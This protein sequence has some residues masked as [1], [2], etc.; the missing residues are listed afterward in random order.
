DQHMG[1]GA[2]LRFFGQD[3]L[4]SLSAAELALKYEALCVPAY[5]IRQPNGLDFEVLIEA[6]IPHGPAEEMT[7]ALNDSLEAQVRQ[8]M[9]QWFW[10]HRRW[11]V[12]TRR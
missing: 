12:L 11:K 10:I 8:H 5:A 9:D 1:N 4:T 6:P 7:Q 3:A 2:R